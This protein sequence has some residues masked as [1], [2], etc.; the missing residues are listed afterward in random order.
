[1]KI[2]TVYFHI[3]K[4]NINFFF[5]IKERQSMNNRALIKSSP[6]AKLDIDSQDIAPSRILS[7]FSVP[8]FPKCTKTVSLINLPMK[9]AGMIKMGFIFAIPAAT[10][11]GVVGSGN[12]E[13]AM[14][15][16]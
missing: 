9:K 6:N 15:T 1:M 3:L 16:N 5:W 11:S 7:A 2:V 13:Y 4:F 12:K 10:N 8:Y 14:I